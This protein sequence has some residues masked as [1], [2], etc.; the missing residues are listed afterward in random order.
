[1]EE[2]DE[3]YD[4]ICHYQKNL[5]RCAEKNNEEKMLYYINKLKRLPMTVSYLQQTGVGKTVNSVRKMGG[6]VATLAKSLISYWKEVV[7]NESKIQNDEEEGYESDARESPR[8]KEE[9]YTKIKNNQYS[10]VSNFH[11]KHSHRENHK[12]S[13][14]SMNTQEESTLRKN[15]T[16]LSENKN[17]EINVKKDREENRKNSIK[18]KHKEHE[19]S[20]SSSSSSN[21]KNHRKSDNSKSSSSFKSTSKHSNHSTANRKNQ[22]SLVKEKKSHSDGKSSSKENSSN[23]K[24]RKTGKSST[25]VSDEGIDCGSGTSFAEALGMLES[26]SSSKVRRKEKNSTPLNSENCNSHGLTSSPKET[27]TDTEECLS[28]C[29]ERTPPLISSAK[30]EPLDIN[31]SSLLPEITPHYRPLGNTTDIQSLKMKKIADYEALSAGITS[32]TQRTK[33]YSGNKSSWGVSSLFDMCIRVLQENIDAL[34]YTGG[35][36]YSILKPVLDRCTPDQLFMMEHYNPYLIEDTDELWKFHCQKEFRA[37]KREE[38]ETWRDMYMRC[39]DEREAKLKALTSNIK[40]SQEKSQPVRQTM[41]AYVD[42]VAK[43][44]RNVARKQVKNGI[45]NK[46][47]ITPSLRLSALATSGDAGKVCVP[48]PGKLAVTS[49]NSGSS[50]HASALKPKKAPLM[51]KALALIKNRYR[52]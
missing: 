6:E 5:V 33:V 26:S 18:R 34:E 36:P 14:Y 38:M 9:K 3:M 19:E 7:E 12:T 8:Q 32:K 1:M 23:S 40:Q 45:D 10:K 15:Q 27:P 46:P 25:K 17:G 30:L 31:L 13:R 52:R 42:S 28:P 20:S 47:V 41:L 4:L 43:P 2:K 29:L 49:V 24:K 44:P 51:Q 35:V 22:K 37:K 11:H 50:N 48:N 39:L 21:S 16:D